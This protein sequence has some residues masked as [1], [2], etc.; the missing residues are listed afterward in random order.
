MHNKTKGV[1]AGVAGIA[2]LAGGSTFALWKD[3]ANVVGGVITAGNLDV[4]TSAA[5]AWKDV[6]DDR[7]NHPIKD[8]TAFR[9]VPGDT[10]QGTLGIDAALEGDNMVA[11]LGFTLAGKPVAEKPNLA[12]KVD[13]TYTVSDANGKPLEG[14]AGVSLGDASR[15]TLRSTDNGEPADLG[16]REVPAALDGKTDFVVV[17]TATFTG[18]TTGRDYAQAAVDL[19]HLGVTLT[20][21][22]TPGT[23][24]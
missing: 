7:E 14:L 22:R 19:Q 18:E 10:I 6:S 3:S 8:L 16:I 5:L 4:A 13:I 20:Q 21:S 23:G 2:L 15:L 12:D 11:D 24:A 1:I 17:V 9:M